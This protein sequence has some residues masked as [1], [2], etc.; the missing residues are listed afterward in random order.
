MEHIGKRISKIRK[1]RKI[2]QQNLAKAA[3]IDYNTLKKIETGKTKNPSADVLGRVAKALNIPSSSLIDASKPDTYG[4]DIFPFLKLDPNKFRQMISMILEQKK[5][6]YTDIET[7]D[8]TGDKQ[9]D[10][11]AREIVSGQVSIE[12][13]LF[14]VK[15]YKEIGASNLNKEL[16]GIKKHFF[17]GGNISTPIAKIIF[18][19]ANSPTSNMKDQVR[20]YADL[21]SIPKP[22]FWEARDLDNMCKTYQKVI[23]RFFNGD[24]SALIKLTKKIDKKISQD[25]EN[26]SKQF[27][28]IIEE[29][30]N[31]P[32]IRASQGYV[33]NAK[34]D[35]DM[36][37]A[38]RL[39]NEK[40]FVEAKEILLGLRILIEKSGDVEML[41]KIYNN[42][43][44]CFCQG[45]SDQD[46][47]KGIEFLSQ[48]LDLDANFNVSKQNFAE[49]VARTQ[50]KN[51][52]DVAIKYTKDLMADEKDNLNHIA[53][54]IHLLHIS[55]KSEEAIKYLPKI[56]NIKEKCGFSEGLCVSVAQLFFAQEDLDNARE[57]I[58]IG[59]KSFPDSV[60]LNQLKGSVLMLEVHKGGS[61][62][63]KFDIVPFFFKS[64]LADEAIRYFK[65]ALLNAENADFPESEINLI[66]FELYGAT[67]ISGK[68]ERINISSEKL[69]KAQKGNKLFLDLH[70][71]LM[72]KKNYKNAFEIAQDIIR[73]G[74][75]TYE[76]TFDVAEKFYRYGAPEYVIKLFDG[77]YDEAKE[78]KDFDYWA[79]LSISYALIGKKSD[80]LRVM[81]DA[82]S[83][84]YQDAKIY[85]NVLSHYSALVNRYKDQSESDRFVK[86][87]FELQKVSPNEKI[88][89]PIKAREEDG[90]I[91]Q[92]IKDFLINTKK[93]FNEK[94]DIFLS[95]PIPIYFLEQIFGRPFS[96]AIKVPRDD[97]DFDFVL[98]YNSMDIEFRKAQIN[99]FGNIKN[100]V[101]DYCALLNFA[102]SGQLGLF[103][104]LKKNIVASEYLLFKVQ[105][106]LAVN[107]SQELRDAWEFLK[108]ED[109]KLLPYQNHNKSEVKELATIQKLFDGWGEWLIQS[110]VH[111]S[112]KGFCLLT[113]DLRLS[114]LMKSEEFKVKTLNS[115]IFFYS[116]L[117]LH[118][119]DK[120]Q[121]SLVL[122]DLAELFFHFI[123]FDG[124]DLLNIV[125]DDLNKIRGHNIL[126]LHNLNENPDLKI[127]LR[128]YHLLN[129]H[130]LT[131]SN[132]GS[133]LVVCFNFLV[134][135]FRL[136][137]LDEDK[138]NWT[139]FL[140]NFFYDPNNTS[141]G[142][143]HFVIESWILLKKLIPNDSDG[144]MSE[145]I[146]L[147]RSKDIRIVIG[148]QLLGSK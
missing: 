107:E 95:Q 68:Y 113:D 85:K 46:I 92:E 132:V 62:S 8:G 45:I 80:A 129:Q 66:N 75:K 103:K 145:K 63:R 126:A 65:K 7:L 112:N 142:Y 26:K 93:E 9:R 140:T 130:K 18:C 128:V 59:L 33:V 125:L 21:I 55:E 136:S 120:K 127:S 13:T 123:P 36:Q 2:T 3:D 106:E 40:N 90:S 67:I 43:G 37:K 49:V 72:I 141:K 108:S 28:K 104:V 32:T 38:R 89:Q 61:E 84:F 31:I 78:R 41:K 11:I 148:S 137:V 81:N 19:L 15:R 109:V 116:G 52:Y 117:Q 121:Y 34:D 110:I 114:Y 99:D 146:K 147:I 105:D 29:I 42:L 76:I 100:L 119:I 17:S 124:E 74:N 133:F 10:I 131:G 56:L 144:Y 73:D 30:K 135:F 54:F 96:E 35:A 94:R 83:I 86:N 24:I 57:Y 22:T 25:S 12:Y 79:L 138:I 139:L 102:R 50:R 23:S 77:I 118:F 88:I 134:R 6:E 122:A 115:F 20:D 1:S 58:N 4:V 51:Y 48:A 39:I 82:K 70:S 111:C 69:N 14:Q 87:V 143:V 98:P 27:N 71:E 16:D 64:N 91:S 47:N 60:N 101:I 44:V 97:F 53:I 5:D